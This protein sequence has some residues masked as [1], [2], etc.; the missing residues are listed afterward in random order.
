MPSG[1]QRPIAAAPASRSVLSTVA[2]E[3][4]PHYDA[5]H[6]RD[7]GPRARQRA[8][9]GY[10]PLLG[11]EFELRLP[12]DWTADPHLSRSWKY[13]LHTLEFLDVLCQIYRDE[14]DPKPLR[15]AC[16]VAL[17]WMRQNG[18]GARGVSQFAWYDMAVAI[19]GPYI[20]YL[21]R[22]GARV[23]I[24]TEAE[25]KEFLGSSL[26]HA[27]FLFDDDN[28]AHGHNHGLFQDEG[29]LLLAS[30]LT[31]VPG[32]RDW[33]ARARERAIATIESTV[34]VR[35]GIHLEHSP[36]YHCNIVNLLRRLRRRDEKLRQELTDLAQRMESNA[37]WLVTPSE[38][39]PPVGDTDPKPAREWA[40]RAATAATGICGFFDAG[41]GIARTRDAYLLLTAGYHS[42]A[43]KHA[44][45][46]SFV[47]EEKGVLLVNDAGRFTYDEEDPRRQHARSA[48]AHNGLIADGEPSSW[49]E[50]PPY[51]SGLEAVG[52]GAGWYAMQ[53]RNPLLLDGGIEHRRLLLYKP[54]VSLIVLDELTAD[55]EHSYTRF[56]HFGP[57]LTCRQVENR[58]LFEGVARGSVRDWGSPESRVRLVRG[59]RTPHLQGW[60]YPAER[61]EA[62]AFALELETVASSAVLTTILS[63]GTPELRLEDVAIDDE[64]VVIRLAAGSRHVALGITR[65]N[66]ELR[67][68]ELHRSQAELGPE[69]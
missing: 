51:G 53:A 65:S 6:V 8:L 23:G 4:E 9:Q 40:I 29:L 35:D 57:E 13:E 59:Q 17:D 30:Y 28:Y 33:R 19:R 36:A 18:Q 48:P 11:T 54:T 58:V 31:F 15:T 44:D 10:V 12:I 37:G 34:D 26:Q 2:A 67:V 47:L 39:L 68:V 61:E 22:A 1:S 49:K 25:A 38:R 63:I 3:P 45:E 27:A 52:S 60:F 42:D 66:D 32:A 56:L 7:H 41:Y 43:H 64:R 46:L 20:A 16:D 55:R 14:G 21:L 62:E 24:L 50:A 69:A 5:V